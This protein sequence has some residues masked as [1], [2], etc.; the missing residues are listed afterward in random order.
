ME[1]I[2]ADKSVLFNLNPVKRGREKGLDDAGARKVTR[3]FENVRDDLLSA[4]LEGPH[5]DI[6][7][8]DEIDWYLNVGPGDANLFMSPEELAAVMD[9]EIFEDP[10]SAE[11]CI[12]IKGLELEGKASL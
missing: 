11:L 5:L 12:K 4:L 3:V 1:S 2:P 7:K 6:A 10:S 9:Q 8:E